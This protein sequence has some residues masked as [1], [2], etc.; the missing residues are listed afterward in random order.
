MNIVLLVADTLRL[1]DIYEGE[2][3]LDFLGDCQDKQ[4]VTN[5]YTNSP[6][7]VPAHATMFT[8]TLPSEHGTTSENLLFVEENDLLASL[9]ERGYMNV[10]ISENPLFSGATNLDKQ[11]DKFLSVDEDSLDGELWRK[12]DSSE[13]NLITNYSKLILSAFVKR[14]FETIK[15]AWLNGRRKLTCEE[16]YNP[17]YSEY[18]NRK[19]LDELESGGSEDKFIMANF[20]PTHL[21][22]TFTE[23]E[24]RE[25]LSDLSEEEIRKLSKGGA[26][27]SFDLDLTDE[28]IQKRRKIYSASISYLDSLISDLI[29]ESP[30]DTVFIILGDHGELIGE[31][32]YNG[33]NLLGHHFGT[34]SE[35]IRVPLI[36]APSQDNVEFE[37][38]VD[39]TCLKNLIL[40]I[41][42]GSKEKIGKQLIRSEYFGQS[43]FQR[44]YLNKEP[45]SQ[46]AHRKSFSLINAQ[47]KYDITT[48]GK[49]LF[50]N[51]ETAE[52]K[53]DLSKIPEEMLEKRKIYYDWRIDDDARKN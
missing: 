52:N 25:L 2:G 12:F 32:Q 6:W 23:E 45:E 18:T 51:T 14:D 34:F 10:G 50:N 3:D 19:V 47:Y 16:E 33:T 46:I 37:G 48:D 26:T 38:L 43:G 41:A 30:E 4:I 20:M 7:T 39:H 49:C 35:L 21:P 27:D 8:S 29:S 40:S 15:S 44:N 28:E 36:V 11:F 13:G 1:K 5:Y 42:D 53:E 24:R 31:Q 17:T 22:Y 9:K